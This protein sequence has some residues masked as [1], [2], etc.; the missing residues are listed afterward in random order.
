MRNMYTGFAVLLA[1]LALGLWSTAHL[2]S[3]TDDMHVLVTKSQEYALDENSAAA[4]E[5][6][7]RAADLWEAEEWYTHVFVRHTEVDAVSDAVYELLGS[8][9]NEEWGETTGGYEKLRYH[10]ESIRKLEHLSVGSIF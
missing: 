7:L 10:L 1:A 9:L 6:L 5:A 8:L 2:D 3:L 4:A